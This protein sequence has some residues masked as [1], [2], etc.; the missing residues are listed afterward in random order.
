MTADP[1]YSCEMARRIAAVW[2]L[3]V[4]ALAACGGQGGD[5]GTESV[6][7]PVRFEVHAAGAEVRR[8]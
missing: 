5:D 8:E 6:P 3:T 7:E 1:P 2:M 4:A